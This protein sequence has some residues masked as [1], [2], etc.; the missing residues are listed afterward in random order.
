MTINGNTIIADESKV[1]RRISD[2][3][4]FGSEITLGYTWYINGVKLRKPLFELP[5]HYEEVTQEQLDEEKKVSDAVGHKK[6]GV[7][8][9]G[10]IRE[11]YTL[12]EELAI[13]RQRDTKPERFA[14]YDAFCEAC[15]REGR[16]ELGM[17]DSETN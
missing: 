8:V 3:Q 4:V 14:E 5:E 6:L 13:L 16:Q 9:D 10:K 7:V 17:T 12:S 15:K 2:R 1:L 11:R